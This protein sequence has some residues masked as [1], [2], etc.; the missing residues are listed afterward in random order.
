MDMHCR[1]SFKKS[2]VGTIAL[3]VYLFESSCYDPISNRPTNPFRIIPSLLLLLW[4]RLPI[5]V[6]IIEFLPLLAELDMDMPTPMTDLLLV[7]EDEVIMLLLLVVRRLVWLDMPRL[8][9][10]EEVVDLTLL[11]EEEEADSMD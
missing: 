2:Q 1:L 5:C 3:G 6:I 10:E 9:L 8:F 4:E 11:F 7:V